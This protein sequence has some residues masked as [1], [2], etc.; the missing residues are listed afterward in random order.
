[1]YRALSFPNINVIALPGIL[2]HNTASLVGVPCINSLGVYNISKAF[3][4]APPPPLQS[5]V[6][7]ATLRRI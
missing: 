6:T 4:A 1:M 5:G 3:T 2:N 7:N